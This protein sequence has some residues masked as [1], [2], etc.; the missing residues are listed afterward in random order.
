MS[1]APTLRPFPNFNANQDAEALKKAMKGMGCDEKLIMNI[2]CKRSNDQRQQIKLAYKT[3][4][5]DDLTKDLVKELKGHFEDL[6]V[7]LMHTMDEYDAVELHKAM[8]GL[9]TNEAVLI[10]ILASRTNAEI[11]AFKDA[12]KRLYDRDLE[13]AISSET[14]SDFKHL[15]VSLV[16]GNRDETA[17]TDEGMAVAKAKQLFDAGEKKNGN[18]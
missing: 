7:A 11:H 2:L 10:E 12:Y 8:K 9:G 4:Y 17:R 13:K 6:I 3:L 16:Q 14:S 5:G 15:L 1:L 18:G